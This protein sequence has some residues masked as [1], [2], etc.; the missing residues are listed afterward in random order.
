LKPHT[1]WTRIALPLLA[2]GV[3]ISDAATKAI[4][5]ARIPTN[6][7]IPVLGE[8]LRFTHLYNPGAAFGISV[9]EYSR[10]VFLVLTAL[11]LP[12][13]IHLYRTTT[14]RDWLPRLA[15]SLVF[16]GAVGNLV[17]RVFVA[18][19]VVDWIDV[20]FGAVRWPAFN[21]ADAA[22]TLGAV[23]LACSFTRQKEPARR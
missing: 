11:A 1:N 18:R 7:R 3:V 14:P 12:V 19:G 5:V 16:G 15:T 23:L 10:V 6:A 22:I 2:A 17:N 8:Y 4:T 21:V 13:L 20:G 9:G